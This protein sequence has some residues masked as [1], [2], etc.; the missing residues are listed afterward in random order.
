MIFP[1][2]QPLF[3]SSHGLSQKIG[4]ILGEKA[5]HTGTLDPLA[6]GV[7]VVLTG[8]DRF[9]KGSLQDWYKTYDFEILWGVQTD[10]GDTLGIPKIGEILSFPSEL[11]TILQKFPQKYDQKIP[12]F[13]ARRIDGQSSFDFAKNG[14]DFPTQT[15]TVS[16]ALE[17]NFLQSSLPWSEVQNEV[18]RRCQ[19]VQGNFRQT[20]I[21]H[22]WNELDVSEQSTFSL[23]RHTV[24]A[25]PRTYVR[26]LVQDMAELC[27]RPATTW[28]ITRTKN[29]PYEHN[30][31]VDLSEL[32]DLS[33]YL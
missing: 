29:G 31:C 32:T 5:T 13:S 19:Q 7:L 15:R 11:E 25:S 3:S 21:A 17:K 23:T 33:N 14:Q 20:E 26:Q 30:D 9:A 2:W 4:E 28:S 27:G 8:E 22:S 16:T 10:S 18:Q 12:S 6:E 1:V 24:V